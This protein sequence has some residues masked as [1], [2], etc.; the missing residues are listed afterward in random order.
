MLKSGRRGG[1]GGG[2]QKKRGSEGER[3]KEGKGGRE[4][5]R[6]EMKGQPGCIQIWHY[7]CIRVGTLCHTVYTHV[8]TCIHMLYVYV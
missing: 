8:Y 7:P 6:E 2:G 5:V 1:G 3:E 4:E